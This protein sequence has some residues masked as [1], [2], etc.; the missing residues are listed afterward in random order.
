MGNQPA[1]SRQNSQDQKIQLL[2]LACV[3]F[4]LPDLIMAKATGEAP[5]LNCVLV[6]ADG[7]IRMEKPKNVTFVQVKED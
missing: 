6:D 4:L 3:D 1:P 7:R 5:E 2:R